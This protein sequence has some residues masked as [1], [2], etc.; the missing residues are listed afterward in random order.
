MA[1][2]TIN[3][4][5]DEYELLVKCRHIVQS[6]FEENFSEKFI[7]AVMKSEEDYRK[8]K[9]VRIRNSQERRK[10]FDAM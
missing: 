3:I 2:D 7:K 8:G 9:V 4:S 1:S 10:L 5:R 6:E